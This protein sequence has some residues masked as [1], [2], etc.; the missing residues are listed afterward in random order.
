MEQA[1]IFEDGAHEEAVQR[2]RLRDRQRHATFVSEVIK[3]DNYT[4]A[5]RAAGYK[6]PA[7]AG[8]RLMA[9][10]AIQRAI[11]HE[12]ARLA[13]LTPDLSVDRLL[14]ELGCIALTDVRNVFDDNGETLSPHDLDEPT[15]RAVASVEIEEKAGATKRK[16]KLN[17][18]RAAIELIARIK[19]YMAAD[20]IEHSGRMTLEE[21]VAGPDDSD[22]E[23]S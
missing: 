9:D 11:K 16:Y 19:G 21:L 8:S 18:K 7:Q 20:K 17:D 1:Q 3:L 6:C 5:A 2:E 12:R 15:A 22:S 13:M 10:P 23:Q 14:Q 4:K